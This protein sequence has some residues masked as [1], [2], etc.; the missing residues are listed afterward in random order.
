MK[1]NHLNF[2]NY[3]GNINIP[4]LL[5]GNYYTIIEELQVKNLELP[6]V[7][8]PLKSHKLTFFLSYYVKFVI[9]TGLRI[10]L[11]YGIV[12]YIN[13]TRSKPPIWLDHVRSRCQNVLNYLLL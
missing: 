6:T 2:H 5:L 3:T 11:T 8:D 4:W 10:Y 7:L 13:K 12:Q 1:L 9:Y